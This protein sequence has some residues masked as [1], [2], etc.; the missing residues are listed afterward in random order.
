V[1]FH[2]DRLFRRDCKAA[3]ITEITPE[4]KA[5]F[6]SLR[7]SFCTLV[8][9]SGANLKEAQQLMRHTDPRLTANIYSHARKERLQTV[10]EAVGEKVMLNEGTALLR[11]QATAGVGVTD[12]KCSGGLELATAEREAGEGVRT[13]DFDLGNLPEENSSTWSEIPNSC[14]VLDI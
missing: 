2:I 3:K 14:T 1:D 8:I 5:V 13:L 4:G 6:Y 12:A 9:E 7:H 11:H 10:A